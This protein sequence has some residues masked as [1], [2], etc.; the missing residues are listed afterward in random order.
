MQFLSRWHVSE[1]WGEH[2]R[3][4]AAGAISG[5]S[6]TPLVCSS[7]RVKV[8]LQVERGTAVPTY[9]GPLSAARYLLAHGGVRSLWSGM[10]LTVARDVPAFGIYFASYHAIKLRLKEFKASLQ[11][12][13]KADQ[14][15]AS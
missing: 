9:H 7:E 2:T 11:A 14:R 15:P 1:S 5:L 3:Q 6:Q 13:K 8:L 10:G 4:F 12:S